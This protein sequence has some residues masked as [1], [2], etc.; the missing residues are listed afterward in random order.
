MKIEKD[1]VVT[2]RYK[3]ADAQGKLLS[4]PRITVFHNGVV[5]QNNVELFGETGWLD[6]APFTA[7]PEKLPISLQ[8]HGNPVRYRNVWVLPKT[9]P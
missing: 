7:H 1:T 4:A 6:R 9:T 2:L 8:D 5:V 3:V